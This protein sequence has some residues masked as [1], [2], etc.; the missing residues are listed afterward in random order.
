[1]SII[2]HVIFINLMYGT[3]TLVC[4]HMHSLIMDQIT[5]AQFVGT[6]AHL[7]TKQFQITYIQ[8]CM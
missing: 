3:P 8:A 2:L 6:E 5:V 1:M 7:Y 4:S